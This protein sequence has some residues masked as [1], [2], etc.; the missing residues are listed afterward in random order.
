MKRVV[1]ILAI[2]LVSVLADVHRKTHVH[3]ETD[4]E[5]PT[6]GGKNYT[7]LSPLYYLLGMIPGGNYVS[8]PLRKFTSWIP[9]AL[10]AIPAITLASLVTMFWGIVAYHGLSRLYNWWN[11]NRSLKA[12]YSGPVTVSSEYCIMGGQNSVNRMNNFLHNQVL[13]TV[14]KQPGLI[15]FNVYR[16]LGNTGAW[17]CVSEWQTLEDFRRAHFSQDLANIK[18]NAP[19]QAWLTGTRKCISS[20]ASS[21]TGPAK[22]GGVGEQTTTTTRKQVVA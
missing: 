20:T 6:S 5:E 19:W 14:S 16:N 11:F 12:N 1:A 8:Q 13:P 3:V 10:L 2:V 9:P 22:V 18:R 21:I 17:A 4:I 15:R 7:I